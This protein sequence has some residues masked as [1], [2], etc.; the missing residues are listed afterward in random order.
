VAAAAQ[1]Q[2]RPNILWISCED[3]SPDLG[4]YGDQYAITPNIDRLASQ[5][6]RYTRCFTHAGVCA[7]SRSGLI[8]GMYPSSIGTNQMRC[9]G[10]PPPEAKCFPEYLRAAGYYCTNNVK[11]DYQFAPP[12]TAWDENSGKAHWRNRPKGVPFFCVIN[13]TSS[14]ESQVRQPAASFAK[15]RSSFK[16]E[17]IHDPAKATLPPY[18]PD[19]P[20]TRRDWANYYDVVT[21]MDKQVGNILKQLDE[22]GLAD[23]TIVWFW[24]DHGR[25]LPRG[26]R[27]LYDSGTRAPLIL[28]VP[29]KWRKR[30]RPDNPDAL[31]PGGTNDELVAFLDF[32]PTMLA[33]GGV[34]VPKHLQGRP[35]LGSKTQPRQYVHGAR[36][37]MDETCDCIRMVRDQQWMYIRNFMPHLSYGQDIDYMNLMPTMQEWRKLHAA[38]KL[39]GPQQGYF[40]QPKPVE[41]LYDTAADPH[42]I[43]NLAGQPEHQET[44]K[45]MRAELVRWMKEIGDVGLVPEPDFDELKRPGG[46]MARTAAP[47]IAVKNQRVE[48]RCPTPGASVAYRTKGDWQLYTGPFKA[49]GTVETKACRIGFQDSAV[50]GL[51]QQPKPADAAAPPHWREVVGKTDLLDRLL[52]IKGLDGQGAVAASQYFEALKDK[53]GPVRYW[54]VIGIE[55]LSTDAPAIDKAKKAF[56][57]LLA[58]PSPSVRCAAAKAL[59]LWGEEKQALPVLVKALKEEVQGSARHHAAVALEAIGD[60]ARPALPDIQAASK[61]GYDYVQ[62][63]SGR[64]VRNLGK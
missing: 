35:F 64:I 55:N 43:R 15:L 6:V 1:D 7:P 27:W 51:D 23:D 50:V 46:K 31:K 4:C 16:P 29:E 41:E 5:G 2:P 62:R 33:L 12:F 8:T 56:L 17:E 38:G 37:R 42:Q 48:I 47:E 25:G 19:T 39:V 60:K 58:D 28:R 13:L 24:G 30:A 21:G 49:A 20:V 44:L 26:K 3:T 18:Y 14:H 57:P 22:D 36:D 61:D 9:Q 32:A 52:A 63:V 54:A 40:V 34:E 45:R 59:C 11:T 10:V 53:D